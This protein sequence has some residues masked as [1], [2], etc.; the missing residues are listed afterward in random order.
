MGGA[1]III[2]VIRGQIKI[3]EIKKIRIF[4]NKFR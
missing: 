2:R 1:E 3:G 4:A